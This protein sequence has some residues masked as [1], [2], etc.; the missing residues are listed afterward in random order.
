MQAT[1]TY[2]QRH[3][4][5]Y[6]IH[7]RADEFRIA[8]IRDGYTLRDYAAH[9]GRSRTAIYRTLAGQPASGGFIG[10]ALSTLSADFDELFTITPGVEAAA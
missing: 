6:A 10:A 2:M 4:A 5:A 1:I 7:V 9:T 8:L 3:S